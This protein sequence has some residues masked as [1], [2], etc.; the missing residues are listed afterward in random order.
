MADKNA[1]IIISGATALYPRINQTYK[2]VKN[3]TK[4][5]RVACDPLDDGAEYTM[6]LALNKVEAA[7]VYKSMKAEYAKKKQDKWGEF[8]ASAEVFEM[9]DNG[10]YVIRTK[11]KGAFNKEVTRVDQFDASNNELPKDFLLTTGSKINVLVSL[12][13]YDPTRMDGCGVSL[14]LRQVQVIDLAE[15]RKRSAFEVME[16]GFNSQEEGFATG[17]DTAADTAGEEVDEFDEP[18]PKKSKPAAKAKPKT[19]TKSVEDYNDID[20]ALDDLDFE[21]A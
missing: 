11:L 20:A 15:M 2:F 14:R 7:Y 13:V 9:N 1:T 12:V 16:G 10:E 3:G 4:Q 21:D 19:E 8:P 6:S 5:E 18:A 17:F